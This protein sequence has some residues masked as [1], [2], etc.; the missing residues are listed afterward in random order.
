MF[1][2]SARIVGGRPNLLEVNSSFYIIMRCTV[3]G[4]YI[5]TKKTSF[6]FNFNSFQAVKHPGYT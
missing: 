3:A 6:D 4:E 2:E 1:V 5:N